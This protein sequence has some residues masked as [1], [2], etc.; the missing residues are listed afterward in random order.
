MKP[1]LS[2]SIS[3]GWKKAGDY[4]FGDVFASEG[5]LRAAIKKV[6]KTFGLYM[7]FGLSWHDLE[8]DEGDE[9]LVLEKVPCFSWF[10]KEWPSNDEE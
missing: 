7:F 5:R 2:A 3:R 1:A 6:Y 10:P 9:K 8:G 4:T